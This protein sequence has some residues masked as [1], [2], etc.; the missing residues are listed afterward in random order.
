LLVTSFHAGFC[1]SLFFDPGEGGDMFLRNVIDSYGIIS[2]KMILFLFPDATKTLFIK[3]Y[4]FTDF[5]QND[6]NKK[7]KVTILFSIMNRNIFSEDG[8]YNISSL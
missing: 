1:L 5:G 6:G 3:V 4:V 8:F 7:R 2:Q